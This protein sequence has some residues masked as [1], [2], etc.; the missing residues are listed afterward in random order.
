MELALKSGKGQSHSLADSHLCEFEFS[1]TDLVVGGR[2]RG[3]DRECKLSIGLPT[4]TCLKKLSWTVESAYQRSKITCTGFSAQ[5]S[6]QS[7]YALSAPLST[8][9]TL[10][11][12]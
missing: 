6:D 11:K 8:V 9:E 3:G 1:K 4:T 2:R 7:K 10:V 12:G 5:D